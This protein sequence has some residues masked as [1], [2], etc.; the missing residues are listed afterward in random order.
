LIAFGTARAKFSATSFRASFFAS[1][2]A[3]FDHARSLAFT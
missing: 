3:D 2:A 1:T